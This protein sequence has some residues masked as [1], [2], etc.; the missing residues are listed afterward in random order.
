MKSGKIAFITALF[1]LFVAI[2]QK[3]HVLT[4]SDIRGA[5]QRKV[6]TINH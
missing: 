5:G 1:C 6:Y 3:F 2:A 4:S